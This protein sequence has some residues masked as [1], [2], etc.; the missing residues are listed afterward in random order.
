MLGAMFSGRHDLRKDDNTGAFFI[1]RDGTNFL[2]ILNFLRS[3]ENYEYKSEPNKE[4]ELKKEAD[5]YGLGDLMFPFIPAQPED[6]ECIMNHHILTVTQDSQGMWFMACKELKVPPTQVVY[7]SECK[8]GSVV[9]PTLGPKKNGFVLTPSFRAI[10]VRLR[11]F[12]TGR[13]IFPCQP[14]YPYHCPIYTANC[15]NCGNNCRKLFPEN[16]N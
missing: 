11:T 3:P 14:T 15:P 4:N 8:I 9:T 13:E 5:F 7:C 12:N 10:T 2:N 16:G 6:V 1:D